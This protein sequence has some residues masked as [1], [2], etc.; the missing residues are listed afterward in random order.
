MGAGEDVEGFTLTGAGIEPLDVGETEWVVEPGKPF[1]ASWKSSNGPG[2]IY[3][4]LNVDQ[5]GVTP[6]T[7]ECILEDTGSYTISAD[8]MTQF[9]ESGASG[10]A[11]GEIWRKTVDSAQVEGGCIEFEVASLQ[12]VFPKCVNCPCTTPGFCPE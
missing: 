11:R 5:H 1:I 4:E 3:L 7:M 2:M 8:F 6:V 12:T 10:A 9:I